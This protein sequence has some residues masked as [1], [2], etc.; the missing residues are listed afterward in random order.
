MLYDGAA[1]LT[2]GAKGLLGPYLKAKWAAL[3][4]VPAVLRKRSVVQNGRLTPSKDLWQAMDR[5][6]IRQKRREKRFDL[7]D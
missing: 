6:W 4:G 1:L 2:Y 7:K 3:R 5:N